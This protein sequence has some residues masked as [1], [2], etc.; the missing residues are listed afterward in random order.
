MKE[1]DEII[2]KLRVEKSNGI[3]I[4]CFYYM[5]GNGCLFAHAKSNEDLPCKGKDIIF[6]Q[7][8]DRK[9]SV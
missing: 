1:G 3:C 8:E 7:I 5:S 9:G 2:I 6:K 4:G